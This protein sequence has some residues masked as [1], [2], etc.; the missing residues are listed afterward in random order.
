MNDQN[1]SKKLRLQQK[2]ELDVGEIKISQKTTA[3]FQER[4]NEEL[5]VG[6]DYKTRK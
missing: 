4:S 6:N 1:Y 3:K 5:T 2:V